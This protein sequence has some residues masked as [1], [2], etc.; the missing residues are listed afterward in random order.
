MSS[1]RFL[2][3]FFAVQVTSLF[4]HARA[5]QEEVIVKLNSL[6]PI[7]IQTDDHP[8]ICV[9]LDWWPNNKCD[10][11][12]GESN[13]A[14]V[15]ASILSAPIHEG[16]R[17]Q[18]AARALGKFTLRLGGTLADSIVYDLGTEDVSC[19]DFSPA[20]PEKAKLFTDGCLSASR[21][22]EVLQL[23]PNSS[24]SQCDMVFGLN[25]MTNRTCVN[26]D[27]SRAPCFYPEATC[28]DTFDFSNVERLM[29]YTAAKGY[30]MKGYEFGNELTCLSPEQY[31]SSLKQLEQL[32]VETS[33][34]SNSVPFLIAT[35]SKDPDPDFF[36]SFVPLV[37]SFLH[38]ASWH[39]YP[40]QAGVYCSG[41]GAANNS[42][43]DDIIMDPS[44]MDDFIKNA[45]EM[46]RAVQQASPSVQT[47]MGET[48]GAYD[49]GCSGS[50]NAFMSGFWF[51]HSMAAFAV[52]GH[53]MFCRQ[54]FTGGNYELV[55][56]VTNIP[57]PDYYSTLL[58]GKLM[59][60][61]VLDIF[62]DETSASASSVRLFAHCTPEIEG[63]HVEDSGEMTRDGSVTMMYLNYDDEDVLVD[64]D[65]LKN[66]SYLRW[67][68][69]LSGV[70]NPKSPAADALHSDLIALN[71]K[72][73]VP[74]PATGDLPQLSPRVVDGTA[75]ETRLRLPG[76]SYGFIVYPFA[77]LKVCM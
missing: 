26:V 38:A 39:S 47:W 14:W 68:Y 11:V 66:G 5:L 37:E 40:L 71:G 56:K 1:G 41:P 61:K 48:G 3:F 22:D 13:C 16:S 70:Y 18:K 64:D 35:D 12:D 10:S 24:P 21:W 74:N 76:Y 7:H 60:K 30:S 72:L 19:P 32:I 31:A 55:N 28:S 51:L 2:V 33:Q 49:S 62:A 8:Y 69:F 63:L 59:G 36:S 9:T 58:F 53:D 27:P 4:N 67:E 46:S 57:N 54:T 65:A 20:P 17:L 34:D 15:N 6:T 75:A 44:G 29:K 45:G 42:A 43:V 50:T 52:Q 77:G 25:G 23:C 73:L